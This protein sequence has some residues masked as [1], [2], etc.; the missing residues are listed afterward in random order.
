MLTV[1]SA[2]PGVVC[3]PV[4]PVHEERSTEREKHHPWCDPPLISLGRTG[5]QGQGHV[6]R[7]A[8]KAIRIHSCPLLQPQLPIFPQGCPLFQPQLLSRPRRHWAL[9]S[10]LSPP[11]ACTAG[12]HLFIPG[13]LL[14]SSGRAPSSGGCW[15]HFLL[16]V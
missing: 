8:Y 10:A 4:L 11:A 16:A 15:R 2:T 5:S 12:Q 13:Y 1:S 9:A 14:V 3:P 6:P 7:Y